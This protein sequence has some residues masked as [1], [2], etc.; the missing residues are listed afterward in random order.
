MT[1][2][3]EERSAQMFQRDTA[4]HRITILHDDGL[5][6]HVRFQQPGTW[7]YGCDIVTWPGHLSISGDMGAFT[8]ARVADMFAFMGADRPN[9]SYW[10]QK[11]TAESVR[12]RVRDWIRDCGEDLVPSD[13][14]SLRCAVERDVLDGLH[15]DYDVHQTR[16]RLNDFEWTSP[17]TG[18]SRDASDSWEWGFE[19][20][21]LR[22]VWCCWAIVTAIGQYREAKAQVPC[23]AGASG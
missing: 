8:F 17:S 6:R 4:D 7:I 2:E 1:D 15:G 5:Y 13:V 14:V 22:Y 9:L 23:L 21:T 16:E 3:R 12:A 11:V 19:V 18:E 10:A 20:W